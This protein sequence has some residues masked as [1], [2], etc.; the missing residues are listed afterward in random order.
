MAIAIHGLAL[1]GG[2]EFALGCHYRVVTD[3]PGTALGLP[4][5]LV[6]L[7]PGGG[8]TQRLPRL[9]GIEAGL[10]V[11]L[12]GARFDAATAVRVG[13]ADLMVPVGQ[14]VAAAEAWVRSGPD[15]RQPWDRPGWH[16]LSVAEVA[17]ALDPVRAPM[18]ARTGGHSPADPAILDCLLRGVPDTMDAGIAAEIG[19]FAR[20]VQRIEPRNMI[21]AM[22]LGRVDYDR[23]VRKGTLP[24]VLAEFL[25]DVRGA[26]GVAITVNHE[27]ALE[28]A[29][30]ARFDL[31][32]TL[33]PADVQMAA[34]VAA[35]PEPWTSAPHSGLER[36]ALR[37]VAMMA[38]AAVPYLDRIAPKD[39][40]LADYATIREGMVPAYLGGP[41]AQLALM[42]EARARHVT[43][44]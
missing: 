22:F 24:P 1:G 18:L 6:G 36:E 30:F 4:E 16:S 12:D 42:G 31:T 29:H 35:R 2:Y 9:V 3:A 43:G 5:S 8:G 19:I 32:G 41:F 44:T 39:R 14:E 15:P 40:N 28:A 26:L 20:L 21:A 10:P 7:L 25:A 34:E 17:A 33:P 13:A 38:L 27:T 37:L 11:L 23:N